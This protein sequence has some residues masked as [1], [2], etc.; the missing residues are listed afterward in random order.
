MEKGEDH[1]IAGRLRGL[2]LTGRRMQIL[3]DRFRDC[4]E[5]DP[6]ADTRGKQHR[7]PGEGGIVGGRIVRAEPDPSV[8]GESQHRHKDQG[9][10][11]QGDIEGTKPFPG[12]GD[13]HVESRLN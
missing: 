2:G 3:G 9:R 1:R 4:K 5:H 11:Q 13:C 6:G 12:P 7:G 10:G 8:P